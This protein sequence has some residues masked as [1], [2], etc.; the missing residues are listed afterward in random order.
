MKSHNT[1]VY[2][3]GLICHLLFVNIS[4]LRWFSSGWYSAETC[5]ICNAQFCQTIQCVIT[6]YW[7]DVGYYNDTIWDQLCICT[8][9]HT[10]SA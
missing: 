1:E 8:A 3:N 4:I 9:T 6:E 2:S 7:Y 10:N 5:C